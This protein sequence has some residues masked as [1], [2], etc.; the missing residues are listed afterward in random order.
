LTDFKGYQEDFLKLF[1]FG[2]KGV[3]YTADVNPVVEIPGLIS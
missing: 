1:G 2:V 3:D